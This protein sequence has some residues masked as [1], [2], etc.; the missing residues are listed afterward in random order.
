MLANMGVASAPL[1]DVAIRAGVL[2]D[3]D[4]IILPHQEPIHLLEGLNL[5]DFPPEFTGGIGMPGMVKLR[6]WVASG[7]TLVAIDGAARAVARAMRLPIEFIENGFRAPG[8][9]LRLELNESHWLTRGC[10]T[11]IA[12]MNFNSPAFRIGAGDT[13]VANVG[14]YPDDD[15]L[16][17]GWLEGWMTL[18]GR[19]ALAEISI[20]AGRIVLF[21]FRPLFRGQSLSAQRL[22][23][24]AIRYSRKGSRA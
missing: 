10:G 6:S 17:S 9:I 4:A 20:G 11:E 8:S 7:G 5:A 16:L 21:G 22:V 13:R 14:S 2:A 18:A 23:L 19:T 15:P 12:V 24:N 3:F 1:S